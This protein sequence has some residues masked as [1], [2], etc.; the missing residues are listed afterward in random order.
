MGRAMRDVE[1]VERDDENENCKEKC[2]LGILR[3]F[4]GGKR[5]CLRSL[6]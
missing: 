1:E 6:F 2:F 4:S 3:I 5:D